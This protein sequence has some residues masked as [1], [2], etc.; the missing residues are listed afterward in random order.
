MVDIDGTIA[1][2]RHRWIPYTEG[3][4]TK[5]ECWDKAIHDDPIN[6]VVRLMEDLAAW[7]E[8]VLLTARNESDRAL[9]IDW[10]NK[11][12]IK[13]DL[14]IMDADSGLTAVE[15]KVMMYNKLKEEYD[16]WL[17]IEDNPEIVKGLRAAGLMV[18][19]MGYYES[20]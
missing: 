15:F 9:T 12:R 19:E 3:K 4:I 6:G 7:N 16:V 14:L 1:D 18:L 10:L 17:M 2:G 11:H 5:E 13:Y 8:I 20:K